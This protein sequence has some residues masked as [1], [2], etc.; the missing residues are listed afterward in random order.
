MIPYATWNFK[1]DYFGKISSLLIDEFIALESIL[2]PKDDS[3]IMIDT[4]KREP[5]LTSISLATKDNK[6]ISKTAE[7]VFRIINEY[8]ESNP[9]RINTS[10]YG[11][12]NELRNKIPKEKESLVDK[13]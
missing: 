2:D 1:G 4:T 9:D 12:A 13:L 3:Q 11:Y 5:Y 7:T 8:A 10:F 6:N